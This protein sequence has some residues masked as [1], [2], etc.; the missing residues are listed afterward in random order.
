MLD[1]WLGKLKGTFFDSMVNQS[2]E[3]LVFCSRMLYVAIQMAE[4]GISSFLLHGLPKHLISNPPIKKH[5]QF[6]GCVR[7]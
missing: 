1:I 3:S 5:I 4:L 6:F 2:E 7:Y